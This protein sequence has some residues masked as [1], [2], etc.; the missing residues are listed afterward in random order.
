MK[1]NFTT[2]SNPNKS[3]EQKGL[4][5]TLIFYALNIILVPFS[6]YQTYLGYSEFLGFLPALMVAVVSG[7]IFFGLNHTIRE[8]RVNGQPHFKLILGYLLPLG[9]S[10]FGN[11]NAFYSGQMKGELLE[12]EL[13][14]Y[15]TTFET[16]FAN[17]LSQVKAS[18]GLGPLE[19]QYKTQLGKLKNQIEQ[20]GGYGSLARNLIA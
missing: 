12:M 9:I 5:M 14:R 8:A 16:T 18:T 20:Q 6:A 13:G 15:E 2:K 19:L 3:N 11:F 7:L 10:F 4:G 1:I 17:G